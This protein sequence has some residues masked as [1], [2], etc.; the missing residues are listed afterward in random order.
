M[1]PAASITDVCPHRAA[2]GALAIMSL[3]VTPAANARRPADRTEPQL[4]VPPVP[5]SYKYRTSPP[6]I[7]SAR[8]APWRTHALA[9]HTHTLVEHVTRAK[10]QSDGD[11]RT[12]PHVRSQRHTCTDTRTRSQGVRKHERC[13]HAFASHTDTHAHTKPCTRTRSL[14]AHAHARALTQ[15]CTQTC[16]ETCMEYVSVQQ[17]R[18]NHLCT[19]STPLECLV[20]SRGLASI[21]PSTPEVP[22]RFT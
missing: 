8:K 7:K 3:H 10:M 1:A 13:V 16:R 6:C 22:P 4:S 19:L 12:H 21:H 17:H 11:A 20:S 15:T 5:A 9:T 18:Q 14:H 2:H